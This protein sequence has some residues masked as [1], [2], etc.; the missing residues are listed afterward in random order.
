LDDLMDV[1][2]I[3][4]DK[5]ELRPERVDLETIIQSALEASRPLISQRGQDLKVMLP[6][7]P[8]YLNADPTRLSQVFLNL[9]DNA[10]KYTRQGGQLWLTAEVLPSSQNGEDRVGTS[11]QVTTPISAPFQ[12]LGPHVIVR[13]RDSGI[14]IPAE[15]LSRIFEMF[16]QVARSVERSYG[17]L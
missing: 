3:T 13:V 11:P 12:S 16:T 15:M 1:S 14:G 8:V 7:D 4:L 9:L 6:P 2:R 17:G 5:L 10:A